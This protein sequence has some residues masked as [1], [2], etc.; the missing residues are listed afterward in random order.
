[1]PPQTVSSY[2]QDGEWQTDRDRTVQS[3]PPRE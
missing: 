1:M 2:E 3:Q